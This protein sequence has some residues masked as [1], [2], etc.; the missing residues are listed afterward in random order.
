MS[1]NKQINELKR[2]IKSDEKRMNRGEISSPSGEVFVLILIALLA[3]AALSMSI[4]TYEDNKDK[5]SSAFTSI[6][7]TGNTGG[8]S[9]EVVAVGGTKLTLVADT[10]LEITGTDTNKR[11]N[12]LNTGGGGAGTPQGPQSS[13]QFNAGT[14]NFGGNIGLSFNQGTSTLNSANIITG[15]LCASG[16]TY[17][18]S[19][20]SGGQ[21]LKTDGS[22][23]LTF[24]TAPSG[25]GYGVST[26][27][28]LVLNGTS[29][30]AVAGQGINVSSAGICVKLRPSEFNL[31][32]DG[33]GLGLSPIITGVSFQ[34]NTIG[35]SYG[36]TGLT[37]IGTS[38]FI[39]GIGNN[40]FGQVGL[41]SGACIN[42]SY[43]DDYVTIGYT[44][45]GGGVSTINELGDASSNGTNFTN[46]IML[47]QSITPVTNSVSNTAVGIEAMEN[48]NGGSGNVA[49]G[50]KSLKRN[51][52]GRHNTAIGGSTLEGIGAVPGTSSSDN[53]AIGTHSLADYG[54][55]GDEEG[56][57]VAI[58]TNSG[59]DLQS[60]KENVLI[61][62]QDLGATGLLNNT[63]CIVIGARATPTTT[64]TNHEITLGDDRITAL[65]C[66]GETIVSLSDGRD[67]T[68]VVNTQFGLNFLNKLRPV[69]YTWQRRVLEPSDINHPKNG[70][71]RTG[72]IAQELLEAAGED[73][74]NILD[75]V[76]QS[77]PE[78]IEA[79]YGN[80]VPVL[81]KSVQDL[82]NKVA[83]LEERIEKLQK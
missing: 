32:L 8:G 65:R 14:G 31:I 66:A 26:D 42:I 1:S 29:F 54:L 57:N 15:G 63:N 39:Y 59:F 67:K 79:R 16:L 23:I 58:G 2:I 64:T 81:V 49:L 12:F 75:L 22:G 78:R 74:N 41:C 37:S 43:S 28:G 27:G 50:H 7:I 62:Y 44:G 3:S 30:A 48:I 21:F 25:I 60:G 24:D 20:G 19:D 53:T 52:T 55:N 83:I 11:I 70:K 4:Y 51:T 40:N 80:L 35:V 34:G 33:T 47:G 71:R 72:F 61:G 56:K 68:N 46:S 17:P 45:T 9:E 69:D 82:S 36:G 73:G 13:V 6:D 18:R 5:P 77:N 76:Y 38:Q 10:G